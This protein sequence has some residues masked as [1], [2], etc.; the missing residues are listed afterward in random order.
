M[1]TSA[2]E[3]GEGSASCLGHFTAVPIEYWAEWGIV[4]LWTFCNRYIS[5][6]SSHMNVI[7]SVGLP[8]ISESMYEFTVNFVFMWCTFSTNRGLI[9][10]QHLERMSPPAV[11]SRWN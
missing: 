8:Y 2:L 11:Y 5:K 10:H 3:A 7:K 4:P 1:L 9:K 6:N